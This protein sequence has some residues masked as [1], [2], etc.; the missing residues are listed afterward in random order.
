MKLVNIFCIR[1]GESTHNILYQQWGMKTFF[2]KNF[3]DTNLT[4]NGINQSIE[5]GNK[6]D[7]KDKIDL[8]IVSPLSR[9]LQTAMNIF[10]DTNVNSCIRIS[11]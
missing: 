11:S 8:V 6:W 9:T 3:Y 5:L 2:D 4:L 1:H 7:N 10:K